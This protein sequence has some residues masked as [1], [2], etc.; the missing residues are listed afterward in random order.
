MPQVITLNNIHANPSEYV[1]QER[2]LW[3]FIICADVIMLY[4]FGLIIYNLPLN[5]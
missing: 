3:A 5:Q 2:T 1:H 4:C